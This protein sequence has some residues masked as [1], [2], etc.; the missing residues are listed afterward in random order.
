MAE[1]ETPAPIVAVTDTP[2]FKAAIAEA[3]KQALAMAREELLAE[4]KTAVATA[5]PVEEQGAQSLFR[6]MALAIAEISDQGTNR[7]RVAPEILAARDAGRERMGKLILQARA[8]KDQKPEYRLIAKVYIG[9]QLV[10]PFRKEA[11]P[12]GK[13]VPQ[14]IIWDGPP[15][16][17]MRPMNAMA[18]DIY[19]AFLASIGG[20]QG[21]SGVAQ[22]PLWVTPRGVVIKGAGTTTAQVHGQTAQNSDA[23]DTFTVKTNND[24]TAP[25]I[26]VLGSTPAGRARQNFAVGQ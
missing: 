12:G 19:D 13:M 21:A 4:M 10:D 20:L 24:P 6:Q 14:E 1:P 5:A 2:E 18:K 7:K 17:A 25:F 8:S 11:G 15:N 9:E 23:S 16:E 22:Q 3:T 26:N